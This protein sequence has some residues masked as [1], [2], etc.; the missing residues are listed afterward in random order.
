MMFK[1]LLKVGKLKITAK[2]G[3]AT[4]WRAGKSEDDFLYKTELEMKGNG[5]Y[6]SNRLKKKELDRKG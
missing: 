3:S 6:F 5:A 4:N 2:T 1:G